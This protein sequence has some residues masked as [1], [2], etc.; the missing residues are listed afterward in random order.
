MGTLKKAIGLAFSAHDGQHRKYGDNIPYIQ[1]P[2]RVA[3]RVSKATG[4]KVIV[5]SAAIL[6]DVLEDTDVSPQVISK[7]CGEEVL[8]LVEELTNPSKLPEHNKKPR[9]ERKRIDREHV[10]NASRYA[11]IIKLCDR[12]D[13]LYDLVNAPADFRKLYAQ[14]SRLLLE[15]LEG[16][17]EVLEGELLVAIEEIENGYEQP[18][19]TTESFSK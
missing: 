15:V 8:W 9:A 17:D 19:K 10:K 3:F 18:D 16:T 2:L 7:T 14:E 13:N 11:K 1:H 6:H 5:V 12:T 4:G